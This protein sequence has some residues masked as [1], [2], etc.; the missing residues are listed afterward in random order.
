MAIDDLRAQIAEW[1]REPVRLAFACIAL[2]FLGFANV[3]WTTVQLLRAEQ[4]VDHTRDIRAASGDLLQ[5]FTDTETGQRGY[6]LTGDKEFLQSFEAA[7]GKI[8]DTFRHLKKL[9]KDN[10]TQQ[11]LITE[12]ESIGDAKFDRLDEAILLMRG[13][14]KEAAA[15]KVKS[16]GGLQL[17]DDLRNRVAAI[18]AEEDRQLVGR[19]ATAERLGTWLIASTSVALAVAAIAVWFFWQFFNNEHQRLESIVKERTV[20]LEAEKD[21]ITLLLDDFHH[22]IGNSLSMVGAILGHHAATTRSREVK[23]IMSS[24]RHRLQAIGAAQ[25]RLHFSTG[26]DAVDAKDYLERTLDDITSLI[27]TDRIAISFDADPVVLPSREASSLAIIMSELVINAVKHAFPEPME[28]KVAVSLRHRADGFAFEVEDDGMGIGEPT[29]DSTGIGSRII[30]G[31]LRSFNGHMETRPGNGPLD[32]PGTVH[33]ITVGSQAES[34]EP[35]PQE[36]RLSA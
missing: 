2:A 30:E 32:R 28:G 6:I 24:A 11:R 25:R 27:E 8:D 34:P 22:R 10:P 13:G 31:L 15:E 23:E 14:R 21:R 29:P 9:T 36:Q 1:L 18:Q 33:V 7:R 3:T 19:R 16:G 17:M 5:A 4:M 26:Q 12:A 20:E 35:H